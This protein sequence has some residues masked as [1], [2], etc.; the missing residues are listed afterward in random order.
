MAAL[1]GAPGGAPSPAMAKSE[2]T[3]HFNCQQAFCALSVVVTGSG[4]KCVTADGDQDVSVAMCKASST[5]P[6][7]I[8]L[9]GDAVLAA[10][11]GLADCS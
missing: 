7:R 5:A 8:V 11:K 1:P 10:W 6:D 4:W 3:P 9:G 2:V